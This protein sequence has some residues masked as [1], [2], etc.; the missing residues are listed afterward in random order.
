MLGQGLV[1][2]ALHVHAMYI[3]CVSHVLMLFVLMQECGISQLEAAQRVNGLAACTCALASCLL[4]HTYLEQ[5]A[6]G[7]GSSSSSQAGP[8]TSAAIVSLVQIILDQSCIFLT[9]AHMWHLVY[10][11]KH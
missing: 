6:T 2:F 10:A 9:I 1:T 8:S 7:E 11:T 4:R 5:S 3:P